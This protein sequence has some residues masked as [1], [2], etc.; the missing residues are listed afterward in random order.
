M[1]IRIGGVG[2]G[3]GKGKG[4]GRG[5][6]GRSG[7]GRGP[8]ASENGRGVAIRTGDRALVHFKF[9]QYPELLQVGT[10]FVFRDGR[11]EGSGRGAT[12]AAGEDRRGWRRP[13][14]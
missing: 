13:D 10:R 4:R 1:S 6:R 9:A 14:G 2:K 8:V 11:L 7:G 5:G 12:G 3:K